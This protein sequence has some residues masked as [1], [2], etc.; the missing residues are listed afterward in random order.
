MI[1]SKARE[2]QVVLLSGP[3]FPI[4]FPTFAGEKATHPSIYQRIWQSSYL[5][6]QPNISTYIVESDVRNL[7]CHFA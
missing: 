1:V 7:E 6:L 4:T 5:V 2:S 3:I